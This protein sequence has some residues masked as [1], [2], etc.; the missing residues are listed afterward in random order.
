M[1]M[2]AESPDPADRL[3][4][5]WVAALLGERLEACAD[6]EIGELLSAVQDCLS[7]FRPEFAVCE[8]ARRRLLKSSAARRERDWRVIRD[9]G[10]ELLNAEA[11]LF[12][13][14]IPHMLMPF[15]RDRFASNGFLVPR[16]FEA[17]AWLLRAGFRSTPRD[18]TVLMDAQTNRPIR[19][20]EAR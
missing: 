15:Q 19:L 10:R 11:A 2:L 13:W 14:G 17:R 7:L 9:A 4:A 18:R 6:H 16:V 5:L 8:H 3:K 12:R 1:R 20:F